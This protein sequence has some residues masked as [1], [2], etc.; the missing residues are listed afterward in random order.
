VVKLNKLIAGAAAFKDYTMEGFIRYWFG[1]PDR[2]LKAI[3]YSCGLAF[4]GA[5][6]IARFQG[7]SPFLLVM[8]YSSVSVFLLIVAGAVVV[9]VVD[10]VRRRLQTR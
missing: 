4:V 2:A 6:F 3:L 10:T 1:Y 9:G 5:Y 7:P 8:V